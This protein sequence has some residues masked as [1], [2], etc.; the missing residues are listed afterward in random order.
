[1]DDKIDVPRFHVWFLV[2]LPAKDN[3][4]LVPHSFLHQDFKNLSLP[5]SLKLKAFALAGC[6]SAL[7]LLDHSQT[8][9]TEFQD[10]TSSITGFAFLGS[11]NDNLSCNGEFYR[12]A[13]VQV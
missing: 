10:D 9:L 12:F 7:D 5:L 1:M 11:A 8:D 2:G 13:V 4:L 3:L 6:T